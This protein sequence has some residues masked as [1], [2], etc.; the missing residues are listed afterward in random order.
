MDKLL[1]PLVTALRQ[2]VK[3]WRDTG[4]RGATE[5]SRSLLNWWFITPHLMSQ[6]DGSMADCL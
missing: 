1:P 4:Y 2:K 5:T 3:S 6:S